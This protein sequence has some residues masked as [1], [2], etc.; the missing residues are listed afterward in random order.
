IVCLGE[1]D[2][3]R[4]YAERGF[5]S[6]FAYCVEELRFSED[7]AC[8]RIET[9]RLVRRFPEIL[10][11]IERGALSLTVL[12]A[13][14]PHLTSENAEELL[15][16]VAGFSVRKAR[17]WL[18]ARFPAPDLPESI[19][20]LPVASHAGTGESRGAPGAA[21]SPDVTSPAPAR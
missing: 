6:L 8:R 5:P 4:L 18:A 15:S 7:E 14:K 3:R 13:L 10:P 2:E 1:V 9:A 20:K 21:S 16:G 17:E 11:F 19:R 12:A